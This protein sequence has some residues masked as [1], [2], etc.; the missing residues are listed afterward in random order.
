[1]RLR[2]GFVL[3]ALLAI[4]AGAL[5]L[6]PRGSAAPPLLGTALNSRP[7]PAFR[8]TDQFGNIVSPASLR[9]K[10]VALTFSQSHC[11]GLCPLIAQKLSNSV[12]ALGNESRHVAVVAIS[13]DPEHDTPASIKHFSQIHGLYHRWLYLTAS[14]RTLAPIWKS[15]YVYVAPANAPEKIRE[16]HT[17]VIYLIDGQGR[18]RVLLAGNPSQSVLNGDIRNLLGLA[19]APSLAVSSPAARVGHP[20]PPVSLLSTAD[21]RVQLSQF[22]GHVVLL[23]FWA[24]WCTACRSEMPRLERWYVSE[25]RRG[26]VVLGVDQEESAHDVTSYTRRLGISYPLLLDTNGIASARYNVIYMPTTLVVDRSGTI[27]S[28]HVGSLKP[29]F[30]HSVVEP[31]LTIK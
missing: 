31:L 12:Q 30:L 8:L 24:T 28:I 22:R 27:R 10:V 14:R 11:T 4:G 16:A 2:N 6:V 9:G 26:L 20:A 29:S 23:N 18:E 1:M 21:R 19:N 17:S 13:A 15:Y 25:H 7:A 5:L 3:V